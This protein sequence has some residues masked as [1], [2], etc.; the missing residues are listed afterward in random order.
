LATYPTFTHLNAEFVACRILRL[1]NLGEA[2]Q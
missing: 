1:R 2:N